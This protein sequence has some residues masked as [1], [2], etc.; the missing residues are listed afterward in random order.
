L[1]ARFLR[2]RTN[3]I[4]PDAP[5]ERTILGITVTIEAGHANGL[6]HALHTDSKTAR[7][8]PDNPTKSIEQLT[9]LC[10][11]LRIDS[12]LHLPEANVAIFARKIVFGPDGS[13]DTSPLPWSTAKVKDATD[14]TKRGEDGAEGRPAGRITLFGGQ[15]A[16]EPT[17]K[18]RT[19]PAGSCIY[20]NGGRGQHAGQGKNGTDGKSAAVFD[21]AHWSMKDSFAGTTHFRPKFNP[22]AYFVEHQT[23]FPLIPGKM[24]VGHWGADRAPTSGE[25]AWP[26]GTPG[27]GGDAGQLLTNLPEAINRFT[28]NP[29]DEGERARPVTG[30]R[31][32]EPRSSARYRLQGHYNMLGAD[33]GDVTELEKKVTTTTNGKDFPAKGSKSGQGKRPSPVLR[34]SPQIWL[35]PTLLRHVLLFVRDTYLSN[36][37]ARVVELLDA[38]GTTLDQGPPTTADSPWNAD[39]VPQWH[40]AAAEVASLRLQVNLKEDYFGNP[41]GYAPL[42]S[43]ASAWRNYEL[44]TSTA[45]R[46]LLLSNWVE[47]K[48]QKKVNLARASEAAI[49]LLNKDSQETVQKMSEAEAELLR[50]DREEKDLDRAL[51]KAEANLEALR[52]KLFNEA[53]ADTAR[54]AQITFAVNLGAALLQVVPVGQPWVGMA[55]Q[56][57]PTINDYIQGGDSKTAIA[58]AKDTVKEAMEASK[59]AKAEA[60]K[61]AKKAKDEAKDTDGKDKAKA[62]TPSAWSVAAKGLGPAANMLGNAYKAMQLPEAEIDA[63]LNKLTKKSAEWAKLS[64]ELRD[65]A[66]KKASY[67]AASARATQALSEGYARASTNASAVVSFEAQRNE[68]LV[69]LDPSALQFMAELGQRAEKALTA[70]L[71]LLVRAYETT[72]FEPAKVDWAMKPVFD[73]IK[74]LIDADTGQTVHDVL[75]QATVLEPIFMSNLE[76][77]HTGLLKGGISGQRG[78]R[79][80]H[81]NSVSRELAIGPDQ[82]ISLNALNTARELRIDPVRR[83]L[84]QPQR[85]RAFLANVELAKISFAGPVPASGNMTLTL[86]VD[87][88]GIIRVD[89]HLYALRGDSPRWWQ[90]NYGFGSGV[91]HPSKPS[92]NARDLLNILFKSEGRD[93]KQKLARPPLWSNLTLTVS[94]SDTP[95]GAEPAIENLLF[96]VQCDESIA[97]S[98]QVVLDVAATDPSIAIELS[99]EDLGDRKDGIG[100]FY[101]VYSRNTEVA[102]KAKPSQGWRFLRWEGDGTSNGDTITVGL[103]H[104]ARVTAVC[105]PVG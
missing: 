28:N 94:Y 90:W 100:N 8:S 15:I 74:A 49:E 81:E 53:A 71:Y 13:L 84:V 76:N 79:V 34:N 55:G 9:I 64:E 4:H 10:D 85:Q 52:T 91:A 43:L 68:G 96:R 29:G 82:P 77:L 14:S 56:L 24:E 46:T 104:D 93:I 30:G 44:E 32:G 2:Q 38:Y 5:E 39:L 48:A 16:F 41:A 63:A 75:A 51:D 70:S 73:K 7:V 11:V 59:K 54:K 99:N 36:D 31:A 50:L 12:P 98:K 66:E 3:R 37:M 87:D 19:R 26:P 1:D 60:K 78:G 47:A 45:L 40:A 83:Q 72:V 22:P 21:H 97:D 69:S 103:K 102:L 18:G 62:K 89:Q 61:A 88:L 20:A 17:A 27:S 33:P 95:N 67:F 25:D 65:L 101:R 58:K 35:H 105:E 86:T 92:E 42:L 80:I 57:A 6:H 23:T